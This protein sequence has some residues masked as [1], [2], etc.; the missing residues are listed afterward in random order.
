MTRRS[1]FEAGSPLRIR[2]AT[3][4]RLFD[5]LLIGGY[6]VCILLTRS[7]LF[8]PPSEAVD[9]AV[10]QDTPEPPVATP[11]SSPETTATPAATPE[12]TGSNDLVEAMTTYIE[13]IN[14]GFLPEAQ[15]MRRD[16]DLPS[17]EKLASTEKMELVSFAFYPRRERDKGA[18]WVEIKATRDTGEVDTFTGRVDW[19]QQD[20]KWVTTMWDSKAAKPE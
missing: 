1:I 20:G 4:T 15:G 16:P 3:L 13:L 12:A 5:L 7:L 19:E 14:D 8:G 10:L 18:L 11:A 17:L 2:N 6:L 9:G